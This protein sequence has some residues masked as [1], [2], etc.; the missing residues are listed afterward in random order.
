MPMK[1]HEIDYVT[2]PR[3]PETKAEPE[4]VAVIC[5]ATGDL[6]PLQRTGSPPAWGN[7]RRLTGM[8]FLAWDDDNP[9]QG[10]VYLGQLVEPS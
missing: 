6:V 9:L 2:N 8:L 10:I 4:F 7:V 3:P 5:P 1:L